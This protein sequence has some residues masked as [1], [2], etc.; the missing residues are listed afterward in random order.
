ML[1]RRSPSGQT[2]LRLWCSKGGQ[3]E[4]LSRSPRARNLEMKAATSP[5]AHVGR[6][7]GPRRG[8]PAPGVQRGDGAAPVRSVS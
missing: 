7:Q 1:S 6:C 3:K 5:R 4:V 2:V 8:G